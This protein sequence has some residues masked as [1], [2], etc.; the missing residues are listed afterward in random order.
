MYLVCAT[1]NG[2]MS[3]CGDNIQNR[4]TR[5]MKARD[6]NL[7]SGFHFLLLTGYS[8]LNIEVFSYSYFSYK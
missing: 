7:G 8:A 2:A 6:I 3:H 4:R 5:T 1:S